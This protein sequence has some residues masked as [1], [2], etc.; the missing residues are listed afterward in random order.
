MTM[1]KKFIEILKKSPLLKGIDY[2]GINILITCMSPSVIEYK[3][4]D[5]VAMAGEPLNGV[6]MVLDGE[7]AI[8]R[9]DALGIRHIITTAKPGN[10]FG[11]TAV[12]SKEQLWPATVYA[13][14]D[15]TVLFL[16]PDVIT[17]RCSE[18]CIDHNILIQNMLQ[19]LSEKALMLNRKIMYL[20]TGSLRAKISRYIIEQWQR[21]GQLTLQLPY[22]RSDLAEFL[23][24]T[25]PS[26]SREIGRLKNEKIIDYYKST[27]KILDLERLKLLTLD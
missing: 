26:L 19:I 24:V 12:F 5:V 3:K 22:D 13:D 18:N 11:E 25:R 9:D 15:S 6:G 17:G 20:T 23:N 10:L 27:F 16:E 4:G 8:C 7:C 14:T 2:D 1:K 21:S